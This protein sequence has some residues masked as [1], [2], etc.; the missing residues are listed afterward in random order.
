MC[1]YV[2]SVIKKLFKV[3]KKSTLEYHDAQMW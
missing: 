1:K 2:V 3:Q